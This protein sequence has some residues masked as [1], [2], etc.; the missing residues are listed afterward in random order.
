MATVELQQRTVVQDAS[1]RLVL[2]PAPPSP[3]EPLL[4]QPP[5]SRSPSTVHVVA[6]P[7]KLARAATSDHAAASTAT[8]VAH[9]ST[10]QQGASQA[11]VPALVGP[12]D[13]LQT[14]SSSL[15]AS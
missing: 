14:P 12:R 3:L 5:P 9:P 1:L 4:P 13:R 2:V 10:A 15:L 8:A 11:S 7:A 6:R